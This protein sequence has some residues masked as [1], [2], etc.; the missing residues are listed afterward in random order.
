MSI[1]EKLQLNWSNLLID[2]DD[3]EHDK[4]YIYIT[5]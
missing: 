5:Y 2:V 1:T 3:S 4:Y